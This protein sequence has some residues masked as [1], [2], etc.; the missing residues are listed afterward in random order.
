[1]S[2]SINILAV[3]DPAVYAYVYQSLAILD[4]TFDRHWNVTWGFVLIRGTSHRK[5]AVQVLKYLSSKDVDRKVGQYAGSPVRYSSYAADSSRYP[6]YEAQLAMLDRCNPLPR[7]SRMNE[8]LPIIT[9]QL[10]SAFNDE[11]DP[12]SALKSA[13]GEIEKL[14]GDNRR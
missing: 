9:S 12:G 2:V 13:A 3:G 10:V 5:E 7:N 11:S 4:R 1:M 8:I 14:R 6:W